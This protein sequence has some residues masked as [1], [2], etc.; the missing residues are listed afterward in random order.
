MVRAAVENLVRSSYAL[1]AL[2]VLAVLSCLPQS[3]TWMTGIALGWLF[4]LFPSR[5]KRIATWNIELCFGGLCP[6]E[7][8]RLVRRHLRLC[9]VAMLSIGPAWWAPGWRLRRL[10]RTRDQHHLD[11]LLA[12]GRNVILLAPHFIAFEICG[13]RMSL[14]YTILTMYRKSKNALLDSLFRRRAR[15]GA[16]L[17]EREASLR[18]L[19][20][21]VRNGMP[22]YYLPDQDL[23]ERASIFAPFFGVPAATV[24]ALSRI[25]TMTRAVVVPCIPRIL[26]GG[27]GYEVRFL[28]PIVNF[29]TGDPEEDARQMNLGIEGWI[30]DMPEQYMWAYRRFKTRPNQ[31]RSLYEKE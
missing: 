30:R 29:P 15:F 28:A 22:F 2:I 11:Q 17:L 6:N 31:E 25:A 27:Q 13:V 21:L 19:I 9:G 18:P 8:R 5:A 20:R 10:V 7:R 12:D 3:L 1:V 14:D 23:G 16:V 4:S 26:P 24:T